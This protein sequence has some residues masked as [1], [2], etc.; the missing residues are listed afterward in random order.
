MSLF[1]VES[2][3][4]LGHFQAAVNAGGSF[5]TT[6]AQLK[7][8]R[9]ILLY[10]AYIEQG[11]LALTIDEIRDDAPPALLAVKAASSI[12]AVEKC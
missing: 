11:D 12:C 5:K 6:D 8:Q 7:L 9:D 1:E 4:L 2:Y 10:R 3:L